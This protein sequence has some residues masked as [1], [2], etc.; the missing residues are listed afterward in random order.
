MDLPRDAPSV[1]EIS[2][3][4]QPGP[5]GP[6]DEVIRRIQAF[7]PDA[8]F[9]DPTWGRLESPDFTIEFNMGKE[10]ICDSFAL[11]VHGGGDVMAIIARLLQ[12]LQLRGV[13][14]Q[15]GQFFSIEEGERSFGAWQE[16]RD[17]VIG[18]LDENPAG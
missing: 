16:Y 14:C 15:T 18:P 1:A 6:R 4:F 3:D 13:D 2:P 10:E 12:H 17:R 11:R 5:L 7:L 9:S 8:D